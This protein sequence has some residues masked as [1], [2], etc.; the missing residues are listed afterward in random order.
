MVLGLAVRTAA[1]RLPA[2]HCG[3][4]MRNCDQPDAW[5]C[6]TSGQPGSDLRSPLPAAT[7][8]GSRRPHPVPDRFGRDSIRHTM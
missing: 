1:R 7:A 4:G 3:L 5:D 8:A 2:R 6:P